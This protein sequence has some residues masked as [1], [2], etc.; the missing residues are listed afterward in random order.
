MA[1]R[2]LSRQ[3]ITVITQKMVQTGSTGKIA[4]DLLLHRRLMGIEPLA[5]DVL[6]MTCS[7]L[8]KFPASPHLAA[9][10]EN[11]R[12]DPAKITTDT[13]RLLE[14]NDAVLLEGAGGLFVPLNDDCMIIDYVHKLPCP[15]ILVTSGRLGSINHTLLS[16]EAISNRKIPL[17]GIV[18][19]RFPE[20]DGVI[21]SD[22]LRF[23]RETLTKLG[24][25]GA[26]VEIPSID[27]NAIPNVDFTPIFDRIIG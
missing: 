9:A 15:V 11:C 14:I 1:A 3:G 22:T 7:Y 2:F 4:D 16:L 24:R 27:L 21:E 23:F 19:N 10:R 18:F 6:G 13:Q 20:C 26:L 5:E 8:F 12:I 25:P 17:A